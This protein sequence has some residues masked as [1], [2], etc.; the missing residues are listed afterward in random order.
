MAALLSGLAIT[1][2]GKVGKGK[3]VV[4]LL[5]IKKRCMLVLRYGMKQ[6]ISLLKASGSKSEGR[7]A[8]LMLQCVSSVDHQTRRKSWNKVF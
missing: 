8:R 2:M 6:K 5:S 3:E 7:K 1:H 4:V